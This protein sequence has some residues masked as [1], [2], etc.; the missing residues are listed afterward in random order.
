MRTLARE[1]HMW[2][3]GLAVVLILVFVL[4]G[5]LSQEREE[6]CTDFTAERITGIGGWFAHGDIGLS[7]RI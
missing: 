2:V 3:Y 5:A 6:G 1:L 7:M 4:V